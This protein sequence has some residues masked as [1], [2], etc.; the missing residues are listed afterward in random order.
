[1]TNK[2]I[3]LAIE[4]VLITRWSLRI[5]SLVFFTTL[6]F[7]QAVLADGL[8]T[9]APQAEVTQEFEPSS[10]TARRLP[11]LLPGQEIPHG[12]RKMRVWSSAGPVPVETAPQASPT[13]QANGFNGSVVIDARRKQK[14][15]DKRDR[16]K[17][18]QPSD[19]ESEEN[20]GEIRRKLL[21]SKIR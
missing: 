14:Q 3:L 6:V 8:E 17:P 10:E 16:R 13:Q 1:M 19:A 15:V 5:A 2:S 12:N 21:D 7:Q 4:N 20:L 18:D 11:P 9:K